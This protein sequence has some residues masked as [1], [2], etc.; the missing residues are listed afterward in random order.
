MLPRRA[1]RG[2]PHR[3]IGFD[4]IITFVTRAE[5]TKWAEVHG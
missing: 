2:A 5:L 3:M 4:P 1:S